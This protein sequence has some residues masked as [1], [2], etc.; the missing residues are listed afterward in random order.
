MSDPPGNCP[1]NC[2]LIS[3]FSGA[4]GL[5]LGFEQAGFHAHLALDVDPVAVDTYNWNRER[6]RIARFADLPAV[7]PRT[8]RRWWRDAVGPDAA[9]VGVIGGPPCQSFSVSNS[10]RLQDDPRAQL[11][12]T[13]AKILK[14]LN[15]YYD[16]EF[17]LFENVAGLGHK[18][19]N[20]SLAMFVDAFAEAGFKSLAFTRDAA[21]FGVPQYRN[22]MFIVGLNNRR[23]SSIDL[24]PP[25]GDDS[26]AT[27]REAI[28]GLPD[29]LHFAR[30]NC[31]PQQHGLHP[32]HW[33][34]KPRSAKFSDGSLE[35]RHIAGRSF[36]KL[37]WDDRSWTVAYGHREVHVHPNGCRRLSVYEA[38]L[39]QGFPPSYE[40]RGTLSDQIRLVSDAVP[41]PLAFA[42]AQWIAGL[43]K[44][45]PERA[46]AQQSESGQLL[47][48]GLWGVHTVAPRSTR[49]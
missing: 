6:R 31:S 7:A 46:N 5:D 39:L 1:A 16:L 11:P 40:L 35:S 18:R 29:P 36:R 9:P 48:S 45:G 37:K 12:L 21:Q 4:G 8:I 10:R 17:F 33:C 24:V 32:N 3:L 15:Q 14:S 23:W 41:P 27:V 25:E 28:G 22:R 42:L 34:M 47:Q 38:M 26:I 30:K 44:T 13:Y 49:P 19:N 43:L 2:H 20:E